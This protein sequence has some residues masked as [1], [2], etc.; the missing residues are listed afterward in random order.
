[1]SLLLSFIVTEAQT[2]NFLILKAPLI[3]ILK[4]LE[5]FQLSCI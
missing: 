5:C 1:M 2:N 4:Q 3:M